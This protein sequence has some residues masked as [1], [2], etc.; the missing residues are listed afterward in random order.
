MKGIEVKEKLIKAGFSMADVARLMD[1]TPQNLNSMLRADD[2]KTGTLDRIALA[3]NKSVYFF[4]NNELEDMGIVSE[5][6]S[7]VK[8]N[9]NNQFISVGNDSLQMLVPLIDSYAYAGYLSGF[10]ESE[11]I[12]NLPKI[13]VFVSKEHRGVYRA[14]KVKGDSMDDESKRAICEGDI[15]VGRK[16]EKDYWKSKL[17]INAWDSFVIIHEDGIVIK[18]VIEHDVETGV[19]SCR[20]LNEDKSFYPDF[21]LHLSNVYEIFNVVQ[22]IRNTV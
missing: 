3:V 9:K 17:H 11:Y 21:K 19:I 5:E 16:I 15:A 4:Y 14:F 18:N 8:Y 6:R 20:S 2:I 7:D 10:S 22:V 13:P 1:E 12:E